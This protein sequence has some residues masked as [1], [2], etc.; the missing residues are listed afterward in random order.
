MLIDLSTWVTSAPIGYDVALFADL[1]LKKIY[2]VYFIEQDIISIY[3][4]L[5]YTSQ[6]GVCHEMKHQR[7]SLYYYSL[8]FL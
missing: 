2:L 5:L 3:L 6:W 7:K 1:L 8:F 4:I